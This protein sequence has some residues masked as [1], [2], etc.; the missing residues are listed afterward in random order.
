MEYPKLLYPP[1]KCYRCRKNIPEN[2]F[3][4]R[5]EL[6]SKIFCEECCIYFDLSRKE[7]IEKISTARSSN[8]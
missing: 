7:K 8:G 5:Y 4:R 2:G 6:E 3:F 1:A